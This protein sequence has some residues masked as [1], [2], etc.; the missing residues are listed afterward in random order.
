MRRFLVK[1]AK[2]KATPAFVKGVLDQYFKGMLSAGTY[3]ECFLSDNLMIPQFKCETYSQFG[4]DIFIHSLI[5][6][7]RKGFFLDIGAND[8]VKFNDTYLLEKHGWNG[9]AFEPIQKLAERWKVERITPCYNLAVGEKDGV[10]QFTEME[11]GYS[12]SVYVE[13]TKKGTD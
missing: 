11:A 4:Q 2:H 6:G 7:S 1:L 13:G 9:M 3:N 5:F 12:S 8:P 10:V